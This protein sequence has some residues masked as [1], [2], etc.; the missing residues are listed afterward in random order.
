VPDTT[1][2]MAKYIDQLLNGET[3]DGRFVR[4]RAST[5]FYVFPT[6]TILPTHRSVIT[7]TNEGEASGSKTDT[8]TSPVMD[9][10][11]KEALETEQQ[12]LKA[13]QQPTPNLNESPKFR[14]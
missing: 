8:G 1:P 11:V 3:G 4:V 6:E 10:A 5:E 7:T 12:I 14:Y 2:I 13:S 9:R